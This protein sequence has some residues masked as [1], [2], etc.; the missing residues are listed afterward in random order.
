LAAFWTSSASRSGADPGRAPDRVDGDAVHPMGSDQDD[1]ARR[2][3]DQVTGGL[4]QD[5]PVLPG[6]EGD[7]RPDIGR[8]LRHHDHSWPQ[9]VV[10]VEDGAFVVVS[11]VTRQQNRTCHRQHQ[12]C[13]ILWPHRR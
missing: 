5:R 7:G 4:H 2:A 6:R 13:G 10:Q 1:T 12:G 9:L 8:V 3:D 11:R